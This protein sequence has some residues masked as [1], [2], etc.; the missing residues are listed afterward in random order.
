MSEAIKFLDGLIEE[1]VAN[2]HTCMPCRVE[3]FYGDSA[4]VQPIFKRKL[5]NGQE[6]AY[7]LLVNVPVLKR[8]TK[9]G[10]EPVIDS[11][12][13]EKGDIVLVVFAERAL[14]GAGNRKHDLSDGIIIGLLR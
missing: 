4:D 14:D 2:I 3:R 10:I 5:K 1:R 12:Y 6:I 13:Y 7:P 9:P 8:K 11:P